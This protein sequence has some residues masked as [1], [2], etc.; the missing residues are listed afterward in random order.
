MIWLRLDQGTP[1]RLAVVLSVEEMSR[2]LSE[3]TGTNFLM[4]RLMYGGGYEYSCGAEV[5][6][7]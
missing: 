1:W 2:L 5:V 6:G 7:S 3:T 4:A